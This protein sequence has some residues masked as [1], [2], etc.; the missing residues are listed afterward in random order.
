MLRI[1]G[2]EHCSATRSVVV[3]EQASVSDVEDALAGAAL[4]GVNSTTSSRVSVSW[5]G[6][7]TTSR[8]LTVSAGVV[9]TI[10]GYVA[11]ANVDRNSSS[12]GDATIDFGEAV[13]DGSNENTLF[14]VAASGELHLSNVTLRAG[15][16]GNTT[17]GGAVYAAGAGAVVSCENCRWE[18]HSSTGIGGALLARGGANIF[19]RGTN[20]FE[21]CS[22]TAGGG[23]LFLEYSTCEIAEGG[24]VVFVG[25]ESLAEGGGIYLRRGSLVV[26]RGGSAEFQACHV[27]DKGGGVYSTESIIEVA[28]GGSLT[29][30]GCHS[31]ESGTTEWASGGGLCAYDSNVT[32]G[33]KSSLVFFNNSVPSSGG[34]GGM[35]GQSTII[36]VAEG[37]TVRFANN[38]AVHGGGGIRLE[39]AQEGDNSDDDPDTG[40]CLTFD[41]GTTATF[42]DNVVGQDGGGYGGGAYFGI[43]CEVNVSGDVSFEGNMAE[44]AGALYGEGSSVRISGSASFVKNTA[45]RWGGAVMMLDVP[46]GGLFLAGNVNFRSNQAGRSGGGVYLEN[47]GVFVTNDGSVDALWEE[48]SAGYDGG[49]IA[50]D[51]GNVILHNGHYRDNSAS[52]RGGVIFATG[53]S[54]VEW[55]GSVSH[56]NTAAVGGALYI[57]NSNI[58]VT[59]VAMAG[60]HAPSGAV[61]FLAAANFSAINVTFVKPVIPGVMVTGASAAHVDAESLFLCFGCS[62]E[63]WGDGNAIE[64]P[65][66]LSEGTV[67]LDSCDFSGSKNSALVQSSPTAATLRNAILGS[68]N[69]AAADYKAGENFS[70]TAHTCS[71][72]PKDY[73][74]L[75]VSA[76]EGGDSNTASQSDLGADSVGCVDAESGMGVLCV[77]FQ[78][79]ATGE[80]VSVAG[81]A[82]LQLVRDPTISTNNETIFFYPI[83]VSQLFVLRHSTGYADVSNSSSRDRSGA[84]GGR[85]GTGGVLWELRFDDGTADG[86]L[87]NDAGVFSGYSE[88]GFSWSAVPA[89]GLL[90]DGQEVSPRLFL[91]KCWREGGGGCVSIRAG[92]GRGY[93]YRRP[94]RQLSPKLSVSLSKITVLMLPLRALLSVKYVLEAGI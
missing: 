40:T 57:S 3:T 24:V 53:E 36:T 1:S 62:F 9:L 59:N 79:E 46:W 56:G 37:S 88:D 44:R 14:E 29:F 22:S 69:Y 42:A 28:E 65:C 74:C 6:A 84:E 73:A 85:G 32:I 89:S 90:A 12:A 15:R 31:D 39:W 2:H 20:V 71:T 27:G 38:T 72:L 63:L 21:N 23:A 7:V 61:V 10:S 47:A 19:L 94:I 49:N 11:V 86:A 35:F 5:K 45:S 58:S 48:N 77:S 75:P 81:S 82:A 25:C 68:S 51:G 91:D 43:G 50:V 18:S 52:Q 87:A 30:S 54:L 78:A 66:V 76:D 4:C 55:T 16:D 80:V 26:S 8:P 41:A 60:D 34:G 70:V 92:A 17:G 33:A 64:T 93:A 13:I 83:P 67:V